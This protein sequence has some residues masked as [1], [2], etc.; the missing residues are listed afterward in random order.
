MPNIASHELPSVSPDDKGRYTPVKD[1]ET[2]VVTWGMI[3]TQEEINAMIEK[4]KKS[5]LN[6]PISVNPLS[7]PSKN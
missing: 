7:Q 4:R 2:G 5:P 1:Q 6:Q 3:L